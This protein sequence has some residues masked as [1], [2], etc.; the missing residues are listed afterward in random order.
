MLFPQTSG[1]MGS[2]FTKDSKERAYA[3]EEAPAEPS[4]ENREEKKT[5]PR[6][7]NSIFYYSE[8]NAESLY[9]SLFF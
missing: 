3:S 4:R 8:A 6:R 5:D 2:R 7:A 9:D 1:G